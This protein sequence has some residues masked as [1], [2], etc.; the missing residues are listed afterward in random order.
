MTELKRRRRTAIKIDI[1]EEGLCLDK[2]FRI[3]YLD[4]DNLILEE[5]VTVQPPKKDDVLPEKEK[6]WKTIGKFYGSIPAA[7]RDYARIR[8]N[9]AKNFDELL[10]I[11]DDISINIDD[12]FKVKTKDKE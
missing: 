11:I 8:Q 10:A 9:R 12:L 5:Y 4:D 2:K 1:P 3:M 7:I 6:R